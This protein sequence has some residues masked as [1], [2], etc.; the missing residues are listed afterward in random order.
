[1]KIDKEILENL[2]NQGLSSN[3]IA[4]MLKKTGPGIRYIMSKHNLSSVFEPKNKILTPIVNG[5][6]K[7][8]NCKENKEIKCFSFRPNGKLQ[9]YCNNCLNSKGY[10]RIKENLVKLKK[11]F[12]GKC[13]KC[14]YNKSYSALD[15]HHLNPKEKLFSLSKP[16]CSNIT[17]MRTEAM[18]C[19][20]LCA[21]C[22]REEHCNT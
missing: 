22:H 10:N 5:S 4:K 2:L 13:V 8:G 1:M 12:G 17:K 9:S 16:K 20:L 7:C 21:N 6:K 3:K 15:F 18:K 14:G 19:V 11:E